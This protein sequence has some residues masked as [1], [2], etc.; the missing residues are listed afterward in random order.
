MGKSTH[1][2]GQPLYSQVIKFMSK[3]RILQLSLG[4]SM[5]PSR[6][7][8][9]DANS[10]RPNTVFEAIYRDLYARYRNRLSSDS[11]SGKEPSWMK[12]LRIIDSTTIKA[13]AVIRRQA[14]RKAA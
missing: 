9:S 7:T 14:G 12:R 10:R 8:L 4:I 2:S 11:R 5:M 3:D 6:S 13:S 1:F